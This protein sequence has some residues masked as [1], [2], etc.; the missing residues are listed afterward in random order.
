MT[1]RASP[2]PPA[3]SRGDTPLKIGTV[4]G[5]AA[6]VVLAVLLNVIAARHVRRWDVTREGLYTLSAA[7]HETLRSLEEP[8][9]VHVLLPDGDPLRSAL[10]QLLVAYRA[11]TDRLDVRIVDPDRDAA[12]FLAVQQRYGLAAGQ[13]EDGRLVTDAAVIV[14]RG[15]VPYFLHAEDL[16]SL[17]EEDPTR[18]QPRLEE[19]LTGA[20]RRV[21]GGERPRVC[22]TEGHGERSV[23]VAGD[24]GLALL[25]DRLVKNNLEVA[26]VWGDAGEPAAPLDGCALAFVAGPTQAMPDAHVEHLRRFVD[27]GGNL[28][29]AVGPVPREDGDGFV[30]LGDAPLFALAGVRREDELVFELDDARRIARGFGE[31][32]LPVVREHPVTVGLAGRGDVVV[33]VTSSLTDVASPEATP[34]RLLETSPQAFGMR[35]FFA[36][37]KAPGEPEPRPG[38]RRGPLAIAVAVERAAPPGRE[39]GARVVAIGTTSVLAQANWREP[40]LAA[41]AAFVHGAVAW[42]ASHRAFLDIPPKP[43]VSTHLDFTEEGLTT[44]FRG[45]VL[46]LPSSAALGGVLVWLARRREPPPRR[47]RTRTGGS[48]GGGGGEP[49]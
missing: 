25:R 1:P 49:A 23:D 11:G 43:P 41:T 7:T 20:I 9:V 47:R 16:V 24:D 46:L 36:W 28:L 37:A 3:P 8:I 31:T 44:M 17:D 39:R 12:G 21:I 13:A 30:Q 19:A 45:V 18:S 42:L 2:P 38:D 15:E 5:V 22:F 32:F 48:G 40:E 4:V 29:L 35:D 34:L 33:T 27:G 6:S 14:A 26:T 10:D